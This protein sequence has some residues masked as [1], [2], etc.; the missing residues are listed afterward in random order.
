VPIGA[1][2]LALLVLFLPRRLPNEPSAHAVSAHWSGFSLHLLRKVDILGTLLLLGACLLLATALLLAAEGASFAAMEVLPLLIFAGMMWIGFPVWEWFITTKRSTPEPVFPWR[3]FQSRVSLG[4]ILYGPLPETLVA[5]LLTA[6]RNTYLT[7]TIFTVCIVQ[8]P[9]RL[10]VVNGITPFQAGV[11]LLPFSVVVPSV[12]A[13]TAMLMKKAVAPIYILF[14]GG[15]LEIIGVVCLSMASVSPEISAFQYGFQ[16]LI[17]SGVGCFNSAL[18][19]MVPFVMDPRD[20]GNRLDL[21]LT[22]PH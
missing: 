9:Q 21:L 17:G 4:M 16:I 1:F 19:L 22:R 10:I 11:R 13:I 12:S 2:S 14:A 8:I 5:H 15:I 20:L 7:G 3:F 18:I 6:S